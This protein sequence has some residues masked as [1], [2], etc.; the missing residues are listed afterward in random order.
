LSRPRTID[1]LQ[2]LLDEQFV[3]L[4]DSAE[5]YDRGSES[6]AKRIAGVVRTLLHDSGSSHSL[7]KQLALKDELSFVARNY[8]YD[9]RNILPI[10]HGLVGLLISD[11]RRCLTVILA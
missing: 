10:F 4:A 6:D 3:W 1:D 5:A 7:L 11:F 2:A 9:P 8:T